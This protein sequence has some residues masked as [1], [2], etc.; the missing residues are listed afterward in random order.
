VLR[1]TS[2]LAVRNT[3]PAYEAAG[4]GRRARGWPT[5]QLG[6]NDALLGSLETLRA[7][8]RSGIRNE[9]FARAAV[10]SNTIGTGMVPESQAPDP[11][12]RAEVHALFLK[13]TDEADADGLCDFYGLESQVVRSY[14]EGGEVFVRLRNRLATDGLTVPFQLQVIEA[15]HCPASLTFKN[16]DRSVRAGIEINGIGQRTFYHIYRSRPVDGADLDTTSLVRVPA[17]SIIH[18]Y[19]P[20]RP[21]QLR[22]AP[23][24]TQA[25]I[26]LMEIDLYD[27]ATSVRQKVAALFAG[28]IERAPQ[29]SDVDVDPISGKA[30]ERDANE[31]QITGLEPGLLQELPPG[32]K[33]T[34]S[35]PPDSSGHGEFMRT[36]LMSVAVAAGLPYET[37]TG[38]M[39]SVNDRTV[40][41]IL[42]EFQR[43]IEMRQH[44]VVAFQFCRRVWSAWFDRAVLSG[45][46]NPPAE[47][48][49]DP[50]PWKS[51][52]WIPAAWKYL[53]PVQDVQ[54]YKE[55]IRNGIMT[56]GE[57][58]KEIRGRN[59]EEVLRERK[60]EL[61][62]LDEL[63]IKTDSDPRQTAGSGQPVPG[64]P[65]PGATE[66][67]L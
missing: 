4:F 48:F 35:D 2:S 9:G 43:Q 34:F 47:Y 46:L 45:A 60:D 1:G 20:L 59:L 66:P 11:A 51:V 36:A 30:V 28:F 63:G 29:A 13:W 58:V 33:V 65:I 31:N 3:T 49:V 5:Q 42:N 19:D 15:E 52:E 37:L 25:L 38:D 61:A 41:V 18:M 24:L 39:R 40:R 26:R 54:A 64:E 14:L 17:E 27:D 8:S 56:L 6:P 62:L 50:L 23:A 55:A 21:G 44:H 32:D 22:G 53:H 16:S 7:R 12:F 57:A 10:V 67:S